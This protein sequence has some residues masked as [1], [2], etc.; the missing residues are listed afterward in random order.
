MGRV[1][2]M[3]LYSHLNE[4]IRADKDNLFSLRTKMRPEDKKLLVDAMKGDPYP[5]AVSCRQKIMREPRYRPLWELF[6]SKKETFEILDT[7]V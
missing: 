2:T 4:H 7:Q 5:P 1:L 3:H 6:E